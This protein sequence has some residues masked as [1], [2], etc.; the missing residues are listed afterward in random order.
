MRNQ[1]I[2]LSHNEFAQGIK[3]AVEM[4]TGPKEEVLSFGLMPGDLPEAIINE[5]EALIDEKRLTIILG[6]IAGGSI[7][8]AALRLTQRENVLLI[9]GM[10]LPMVMEIVLANPQTMEEI[11][12]IIATAQ[13][14]MK[15]LTLPAT[16]QEVDF[17]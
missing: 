13:A 17:F 8:N 4:I 14:S 7:C 6:D 11:N 16:L 12:E 15:Q 5:V 10:N 3:K 9:A 2:L 1:V